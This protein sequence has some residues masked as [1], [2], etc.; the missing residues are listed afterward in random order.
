LTNHPYS[1]PGRLGG[2]SGSL[3]LLL[4]SAAAW[5]QQP[6]PAPQL[7]PE[8]DHG[9]IIY[10]S[11]QADAQSAR[12]PDVD[13]FPKPPITNAERTAVVITSDDL[14]LHLTPAEARE[15]GH[16]ILNL[17]NASSAPI[18]RLPLQI[19]S[20][21][22]WRSI[23][24]AGKSK[25]GFSFTQ[26][27]VTTDT[28]HT[29]YAQEAVLTLDKPLAA[30]ASMT[31]SAFYSGA[32]PASADRLELIGT[33]HERAIETDWDSITPT[34]DETSTALRGFGEVLWYPVA[35]PTA[36]FGEGNNLVTAVTA[37]R[38]LNT[39]STMR[40]RLTVLY[41]GD[42]PDAVIFD[43]HLQ[44]L[45]KTTDDS[46]QV[47]DNTKGVA[48]AD[49]PLAPIGFRTPSLFLTA[50]HETSPGTVL[51]SVISPTPEAAEPYASAVQT[52]APLFK[53]WIAPAPLTPLLL[54]DHPGAPFEDDA[55]IAAHLT[56]TAQP[57]T[58]AP[59]LVRG[60]T[61]AF[62]KAPA[63]T[64]LWLDQGLP[65]FMSLLWTERI[66]GRDTAIKQLEQ[67]ALALSLA[68][69][70]TTKNPHASG[71]PLTQAG[72][73]V[74]LRLK[75][76]AVLWQLRE[77]VGEDLFRNTITNYRHSLMVSPGLDHDPAAFERSMEK[78][79][80]RDL[81]WFFDDW[82]YADRG[83]PDLVITQVN[84]RPILP[85]SGQ[86]SGYLVAVDIRN[87]GDAVAEVPVTIRSASDAEPLTAS[88]RV[89]IPGHSTGSTRIVFEG[90]PDSVQVN[91][92]SVPEIVTST[93]TLQIKIQTRP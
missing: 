55:F 41:A 75:S 54:L 58:I 82:V 86:A 24:P 79:C 22:R 13:A 92:G 78:T 10:S 68:E 28:D 70:D 64:S 17:R 18:T 29:G 88:A 89:R 15:E 67:N 59:V 51:L 25:I 77:I 23:S 32:I 8:A 85:K 31:V 16:A 83:L 47:V 44:P 4:A 40:L 48:T 11:D 37:Q 65:E 80:S 19:S 38:L 42:P 20:T 12:Q 27:P 7:P 61:H 66:D 49:F 93:H 69:P 50:Q 5:A 35:A 45:A 3:A 6:A 43:G 72:T 46:N 63:P 30:G 21:L 62:F 81:S 87:D 73:D 1:V 71:T 60:L 14:D 57:D 34:T 2:L 39:S 84:P 52:L 74:Y 91:D 9:K 56:A 26:S 90:T 76:A 53:D 33:P 36:L